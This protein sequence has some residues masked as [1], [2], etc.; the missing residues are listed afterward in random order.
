MPLG[1][2]TSGYD[3]FA[4]HGAWSPTDGSTYYWG[5]FVSGGPSTVQGL[6]RIGI[7]RDGMIERIELTVL[8]VTA[9]GSGESVI[10]RL[11]VN[12]ADVS[13]LSTN[14]T[15]NGGV[16]TQIQASFAGLNIPVVAGNRL[17]LTESCPTFATNPTN[18]IQAA[19]IFVRT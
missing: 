6:E 5:A 11:Q 15:Y 8:I 9:N 17:E 4:G 13:T 12:G 16:N 3:I 18:I 1:P 19:H 7:S 2:P 14:F 10:K